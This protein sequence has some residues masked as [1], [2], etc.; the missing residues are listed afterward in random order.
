VSTAPAPGLAR[1]VI[2]GREVEF[3]GNAPQRCHARAGGCGTVKSMSVKRW[4]RK[5]A[6]TPE[7][8]ARAPQLASPTIPQMM[9]AFERAL[10]GDDASST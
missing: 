6:V 3:T 1:C 4:P 8:G 2:C 10:A 7:N 9:A 5:A